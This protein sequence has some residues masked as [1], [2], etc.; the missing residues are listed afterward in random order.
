MNLLK[1]ADF[2]K[3][4]NF[5]NFS[6]NSAKKIQKLFRKKQNRHGHIITKFY[7][8]AFQSYL[9]NGNY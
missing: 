3:A 8:L 2:F 7:K 6:E 5:K 1:S 9:K 4:L